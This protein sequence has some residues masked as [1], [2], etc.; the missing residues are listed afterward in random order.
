MEQ[1]RKQT[2]QCV[3][4]QE[5]LWQSSKTKSRCAD[6]GTK[7]VSASVLQQHCKFAGLV[8]MNPTLHYKMK[9]NAAPS[10]YTETQKQTVVNGDRE[11]RD[12]CVS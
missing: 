1:P 3:D 11:H 8:S 7:P 12:G 9:E 4:S 2:P 6:V 10:T 5:H